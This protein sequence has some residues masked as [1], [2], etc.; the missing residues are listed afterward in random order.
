MP[1]A[2]A[3]L[4]EAPF[5]Y[6]AKVVKPERATNNRAAYRD[7]WWLHAEARPAMR[8]ALAPL[9]RYI[10]TSMVAKHR[11]FVWLAPETRPA[12]L[13]IVFAREDDYF[14]GVLHS[15]AHE[16]WSLRMG[17]WLGV[18]N[19]PRY[20]PTTCFETFP[21]PWPPGHEPVDDPRVTA[22]ADAARELDERRAAWLNP[23]DCPA[24][25]LKKRTLT[26]LYNQRP[27]WLQMA[28]E[29]LDRAVWA[30]YGWTDTPADTTEDDLLTR[31]LE[32]NRE[33]AGRS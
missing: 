22:I 15:R 5:E 4:Y 7:R 23:P 8:A 21:L 14:F 20:T 16:L 27:A 10:G 29:R 30:A 6:V 13:V 11:T 1:E 25:E 24:A 26:N 32:L 3:A 18:G 2:E 9:S 17:T 28:H 19:D 31:L 33:R 12:N